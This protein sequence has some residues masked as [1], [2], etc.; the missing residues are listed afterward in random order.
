[1]RRHLAP[2]DESRRLPFGHELTTSPP[3]NVDKQ[4]HLIMLY[5]L[6][7]ILALGPEND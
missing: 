2:L 7:G 5:H 4:A 1:M 3:H 6:F